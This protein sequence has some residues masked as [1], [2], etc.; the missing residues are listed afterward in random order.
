MEPIDDAYFLE[1]PILKYLLMS[2][3]KTEY[4]NG[5]LAARDNK[6][7]YQMLFQDLLSQPIK[8]YEYFRMTP[9]TFKY[10]LTGIE[11]KITKQSNFRVCISA[12]ERL[13]VT[14]R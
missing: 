6:G 7:E 2:S 4:V 13:A 5:L 3:G 8:F 10:I 1:N 9:K 11:E 12:E 14:L